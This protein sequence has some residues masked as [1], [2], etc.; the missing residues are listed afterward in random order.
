MICMI[1]NSE[2][3]QRMKTEDIEILQKRIVVL[4]SEIEKA[5]TENDKI[6][7]GTLEQ[8]LRKQEAILAQTTKVY[9]RP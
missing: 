2:Q 6:K 9:P 8:E 3:M 1:L 4:K 5:K 7:Q